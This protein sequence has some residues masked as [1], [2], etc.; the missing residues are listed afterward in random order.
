M[1]PPSM[2][3][4]A[5]AATSFAFA[6]PVTYPETKK[7]DVVEDHFGIK[8]ADPYRWLEDANS[9]DTKA[10]V[11]EQNKLTQDYLSAIPE[12]DWIRKRLTE[13]WN[14]ERYSAPERAGRHYIFSRNN[15]L[16]NQSV[17]YVADSLHGEPR[18]LLDPNTLSKDGTVALSGTSVSENGKLL[19]Y[20]VSVGGSDWQEWRV[21]DIDTGKDL[22]DKI[23]WS[24][25]SGAAW[26]KDGKGFYYS[27]Y[28]APKE[29][30]ALQ[31]ANYYQKLYFHRIGD[32]QT[33]DALIY[34]RPDQKEW[35]IGGSETEDGRYLLLSIWKGTERQN[36]VFIKDLHEKNGKVKEV[37]D[38]WDAQYSYLGNN[39]SVFYFNTDKEAER[40]RII[41][42]DLHKPEASN[43]KTIVPEEKDAL[44]SASIVGDRLFTTYLKDAVSLV[45]EYDLK[46]NLIGEVKLP[47]IGTA[48]GFGGRRKDHETF[49]TFTGF[50]SPATVYRYD[51]A[52]KKSEIFKQPKTAFDASLY[53]AKEVFYASKDGTK[54]PLF[55]VNKK[56]IKL[57]GQNPTLLYGYGGFN[58]PT[59]PFFSVR[60]AT[61]MDMG[62][63]LAVACI[64]GGGEYGKVWHDG[65]RLHNK[66]NCFDDFIAAGEYLIKE[67]YTSS[68]KLACH[69]GSNGGLL[70]GAVVDQ[71]PDLWGAALPAVG[72]MDML[73][74]HKFT[75]GW[76]WTSDYGSPDNEA[77]FKY[78]LTYSP[79]Y[80]VKPG[81]KYPAV[82]VTTGD[83]DDRVVP[84]HSYKFTAALQAAQSGD[85]PILIR[86]ETS[87][88]H[89]AGKPTAK[90]I[91]E[92]VDQWAFLVKNLGI[93]LKE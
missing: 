4:A 90:A 17:L 16:Q 30:T 37:L 21:R 32:A 13:L 51:L 28:D 82:L 60:M 3:A 81:T 53:E 46:G 71:R 57:D 14:Y 54:V 67:G 33:Q 25:F 11:T 18:V 83:H 86:V 66:Q 23:E 62:G 40:G 12:R 9:S 84:A 58:S 61:W 20:S 29:G 74:F 87:A 45:K 65:G 6:G 52:A 35:G 41:A 2:I 42:I 43:W 68:A 19:A 24:K 75:I 91:E 49:Y 79:L 55:I 73:R 56:G 39:G 38:K 72:V 26:T 27:K 44:E 78:I 31:Q 22:S 64:R 36:L 48:S 89:G 85:A 47:G 69:G 93:T 8:V 34:E 15:G 63:V 70:V 77:D 88:G 59:T 7:G 10:W 76:A 92:T 80:N 5:L 1:K 50:T